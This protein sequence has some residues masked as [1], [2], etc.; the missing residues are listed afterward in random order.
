[1]RCE[2]EGKAILLREPIVVDDNKNPVMLE[3]IENAFRALQSGRD[4]NA[5]LT[6]K[7]EF[8]NSEKDE[9]VQL[10]DM[11]MGAIGA[12]LDGDDYWYNLIR[13]GGRDLG[14]VELSS[15]L[16][17]PESGDLSECKTDWGT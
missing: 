7:P 15:C 12:H 9:T 2:A 8:R 13:Q 3:A 1:M 4:P 11:V 16:T 10:A 14:V 17:H 5:I 6:K